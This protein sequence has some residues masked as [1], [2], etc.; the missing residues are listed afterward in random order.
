[1]ALSTDLPKLSDLNAGQSS[2]FCAAP[3]PRNATP[4]PPPASRADPETFTVT[5]RAVG[6]GPP[7]SV[8]M[9]RLLKAALRA[10]G[11]KSVVA[12]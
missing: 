11:L 9:R 2:L 7:A 5:F 10:Y 1:M 8:R 3:P 4:P 12:K 6:E